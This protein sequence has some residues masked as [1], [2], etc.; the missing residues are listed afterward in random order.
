MRLDN[1]DID[2]LVTS[3]R[4]DFTPD[5]ERG[6]RQLHTRLTPVRQLRPR[7]RSRWYLAVAAVAVLLV[8][9]TAFFLAPDSTRHLTNSGTQLAEYTLPDGTRLTLQGGS[10]LT[11]EPVD[12]AAEFRR[13]QLTGQGFFR[14]KPDASHPFLV[15]NG[16]SELRVT[17]TE[18][19]LRSTDKVME[20]EVSQG[21]VLLLSAGE[22][23]SVAAR[24]CGQAKTGEPLIHSQSPNLNHHAW[25]TGELKFDHTPIAEVLEYFTDNWGFVCTWADGN[26][27]DYVVSGKFHSNDAAAVLADIAKLGHQT[28]EAVGSDGKHFELSG[29]CDR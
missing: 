24:E 6:L 1:Q 25:R 17:G 3:Y 28:L 12:Y 14:V 20:V 22:S 18:F 23:I 10:E 26:A 4:E 7:P 5:V 11:Y 16:H 27:C 8:A 21:S 15:S 19:N 2:R 13:V 29:P 9:A